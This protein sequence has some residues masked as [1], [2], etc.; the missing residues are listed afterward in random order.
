MK[1]QNLNAREKKGRNSRRQLNVLG[2]QKLLLKL[3][4]DLGER[5]KTEEANVNQTIATKMS[6]RLKN[7]FFWIYYNTFYNKSSFQQFDLTCSVRT[8]WMEAT[9]AACCKNLGSNLTLVILLLTLMMYFY[10][11][12]VRLLFGHYSSHYLLVQIKVNNGNTR[13]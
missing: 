13:T 7:I 2:E 12:R 8:I 1:V 6:S 10:Y 11:K 9:Q 4:L 3:D 5:E